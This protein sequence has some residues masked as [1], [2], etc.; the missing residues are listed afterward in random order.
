MYLFFCSY[1]CVN[2]NFSNFDIMFR[3]L[4]QCVKISRF[5]GQCSCAR[6][7]DYTTIH[8]M[9]GNYFFLLDRTINSI[10]SFKSYLIHFPLHKEIILT[11]GAI[12]L[13]AQ[14]LRQVFYHNVYGTT[15]TF[16]MAIVQFILSML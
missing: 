7:E 9:K 12:F 8:F 10:I 1:L 4:C 16:K 3:I 5:K 14:K 13:A 2:T 11:G 15:I 6:E